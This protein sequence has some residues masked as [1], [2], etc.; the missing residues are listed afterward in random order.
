MISLLINPLPIALTLAT[1]FGV[2]VHDTQ[3]DRATSIVAELPAL[4]ANYGASD[5]SLKLNE[6]HVHPERVSISSNQPGM[7]PRGHDDKKYIVSKRFSS[8]TLGS[9]YS[10]PSV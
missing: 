8:S 2:V 3:I 9:E 4:V 10:W 7:Q 6:L 1:V 5:I